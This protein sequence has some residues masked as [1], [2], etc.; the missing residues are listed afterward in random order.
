MSKP[1]PPLTIL[2]G[3][4]R[5]RLRVHPRARRNRIH[6][7]IAEADGGAAVWLA[8]TAAPEN[9][10]A[11]AAVIAVL[12]KEWGVAKSAIAVVVGAGDRH[13]VVHVA[14]PPAELA[15]RLADWIGKLGMRK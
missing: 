9:G 7:L 6:G 13:K 2:A 3:G 11:N 15:A 14:G 8:V 4:V 5:V 10:K 1:A 12:A